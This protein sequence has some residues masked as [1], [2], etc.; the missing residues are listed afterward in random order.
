MRLGLRLLAVL[1]LLLLIFGLVGYI[2]LPDVSELRW[3]NPQKTALMRYR[4]EQGIHGRPI[5]V[6]LTAIAPTLRHAVIVAE[7]INFYEHNGTDWNAIWEA[8]KKNLKRRQLYAGGSTISQQLAKN[9]YLN[10]SKTFWRKFQEMVITSRLERELSKSRILEVYLN[11]AEWGRGIYGA[12]AAARHYFNKSAS[13]LTLEEAS[14]LAAIL[15]S[16]LRYEKQQHSRY[17]DKKTRR[18]ERWVEKRWD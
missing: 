11:V 18:I 12:E 4:E 2:H 17:I 5:W 15:P 10:P 7:D 6:S 9:L 13:D 14:W 8:V 16:P 3:K 1:F